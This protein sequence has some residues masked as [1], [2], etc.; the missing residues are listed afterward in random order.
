MPR[1]SC[2]SGWS[3]AVLPFS[4]GLFLLLFSSV[5][6]A[7]LSGNY[8]IGS[9]GNYATFNA[10]VTALG[11]G[12]SGPVTFTVL[13]GTYNETITL[14]A[15][16]GASA[17]NTV[18]FDGG[19]G[20]AA[21]RILTN[22]VTSTYGAI[23]L[24][25]GADYV[26]FRNLSIVSTNSSYGVGFLFTNSAD[27]NQITDCIISLPLGSSSSYHVGIRAS[28][29][30]ST[31]SSGDHGSN[32]LIKDNTISGG[33][34]GVYWYGSG[35]TDYSTVSGNQFIGNTVT[36][37][38]YYGIRVYYAGGSC[39]VRDNTAIQST[40]G[41]TSGYAVYVYYPNNGSEVSY[42][43]GHARTCGVYVYRMNYY[44]ASTANRGRM[45]NNM[46][47]ADGTSTLYGVYCSYARYSDVVY[48]SAR[49]L[50]G[51]DGT[52][53]NTGYGMYQYGESTSYDV[54][55]L[56]NMVSYEGTGTFYWV[57]NYYYE[58]FNSF[59]YNI[60]HRVGTGTD[61]C[62]W[63]GT[64][65][66]TFA[67]C[68]AAVT[69]FHQN[70]TIAD[71]QYFSATDLHS[72]SMA[73]YQNAIPVAGFSDDF[74]GD[75]R[76]LTA[77][78][79]GAD[80]FTVS[81]MSYSSSTV[82]QNNTTF[83]PAGFA[84]QEIIGIEVTVD[85]SLS[86]ISATSFTLNT[87][88]TTSTANVTTAKLYYTGRSAT[89][90]VTTLVGS[91]SN[92]SS[93]FTITGNQML[94][95]PGTNYFWLTYDIA[96]SAPTGNYVDALC[97]SVT[98]GGTARTPT[99]TSPAGNRMIIA[100]MNGIYTINATG[101]G[102]RNYTTFNAA[103]SALMVY[104]VGGPIT[105]E[106]A[107]GT[108]TEQ[109]EIPEILGAST[110]NT[111]TFDG[112]TGN[113]ASRILQ[114]A[115]PQYQAVVTL[116][117]ADYLRFRNLTVNSTN[118]D[119]GY[120]FLFTGQADYN[121]ITDCVMTFPSNS[122]SYYHQGVCASSTSSYSTYGNHGNYNLIKDNEIRSPGYYGIRWNGSSSTSTT[123][124]VGNQFIGNIITDFYY[125]GMYLYYSV[126][127]RVL[128]NHVVQRSTGTFTTTSGY[129]IYVYYPNDG[130]VVANNY[131]KAHYN[132]YRVY[133]INNAISN[134]AN[135]G[136]VYNNAGVGVGTS[137]M[138][139]LYVSY[140]AYA[141]IVYN[142]INLINTSSTCYGLYEYGQSSAT[143][144]VKVANNYI[145]YDGNGTYYPV[146]NYYSASQSVF[147]YNAFWHVGTGSETWRW[148][149][150]DY[151]SFTALR[152]AVP[153]HHQNSIE[154]NPYFV[155][156]T[157]LH[158]RS[159]GGYLAGTP[160]PTVMTDFDGE[161]RH[162]TTPCIGA[163]EYPEPPAEYDVA[164]RKVLVD[165]ATDK[166]ARLEDPAE[167]RVKVLLENVG[168][169]ADPG[170]FD[171]GIADAPMNGIGD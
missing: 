98:V 92:P 121:E 144:D 125:Y 14:T 27:Y 28:T 35:S 7:Q 10:A 74:D 143:Y 131:A 88:G 150:T 25:N 26:R 70:S 3:T 119:Y 129:G 158:S 117:G 44:Y 80:E 68:K 120:G 13:P 164:V 6:H 128:D 93:D 106:V 168:L 61:Y 60:F 156:Q 86:P 36:D 137:T 118:A 46:A 108:Y 130:P 124:S 69:G 58:S 40:T 24:L 82:T 149:N 75:G 30:T 154:A 47:I 87:A 55:W 127:I 107:A 53:S 153:T 163:D 91:V 136:L 77:P 37:F 102:S 132:P 43:Y 155:S 90:D 113:A 21:T 31:G 94:E 122:D 85:G 111:I 56:N 135:R 114:Y 157:D 42:N 133:R 110:T 96:A 23:V 145:A 52:G 101:S 138:Y 148:N 73:A 67:A 162:P 4:I 39:V 109:V 81:T 32:N 95:G 89:F 33:Y 54:R 9:G 19:T 34:S 17:A 71:P 126:G 161:P 78:C 103:V 64:N 18:T 5:G 165:Y 8:T 146:Y 147:D 112:G 142:S 152:A 50:A 12:V 83:V 57:Y 62:Y 123:E 151:T 116:S 167:H 134:T 159:N 84:D 79:I 115:A 170:S 38:D 141:D 29:T 139:G 76:S 11:S 2:G 100:P 16:S 171:I 41:S 48:N 72:T 63:D 49:L 59:D 166:W 104:G 105:F 66:G 45:Y 97:S 1:Q 160:W 140:A 65:Y 99:V 22:N 20:N 15:I 169:I 51:G